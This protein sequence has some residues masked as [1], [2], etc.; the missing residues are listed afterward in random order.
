VQRLTNTCS[1]IYLVLYAVRDEQRWL[2][3]IRHHEQL[4]YDLTGH[5]SR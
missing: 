5:W 1:T 4:S 2:L 3:A